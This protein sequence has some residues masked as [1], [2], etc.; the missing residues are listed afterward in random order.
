M[1]SIIKVSSIMGGENITSEVKAIACKGTLTNA[2]GNVLTLSL[3][4]LTNGLIT[5]HESIVGVSAFVDNLLGTNGAVICGV[6][7]SST[8]STRLVIHLEGNVPSGTY[9][10]QYRLIIFYV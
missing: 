8:D 4:T 10:L 2:S 3:P 1:T 6:R 5:S 7:M 9:T